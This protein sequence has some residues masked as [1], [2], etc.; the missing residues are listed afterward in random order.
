MLKSQEE[1]HDARLILMCMRDLDESA[2]LRLLKDMA[3]Y[4]PELAQKI[5]RMSSSAASI[6]REIS[7]FR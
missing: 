7:E 4:L 5:D 6:S 2:R 1:T 3:E